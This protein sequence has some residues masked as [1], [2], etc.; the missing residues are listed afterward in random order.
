M[1]EII[2]NLYLS[3]YRD[4]VNSI[5][6]DSEYFVINCTK[7]LPMVKTKYGGT[8]LYVDDSPLSEKTMTKN[9]PLMTRYIDDQ[10]KKGH[11]VVVHCF[12][13]QQRSAA[14]VATY[15]I[16]KKGYSYDDAIKYIK[17][18]KHDA[19]YDGVHFEESIKKNIH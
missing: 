3:N 19:F 10:L 7:D 9:L 5:D 13:G 14:V 12:A 2:P 18:K 6:S 15:L 4:V 16:T 17:R 11:K 1:Y 8:R